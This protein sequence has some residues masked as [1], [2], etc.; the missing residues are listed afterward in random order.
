MKMYQVLADINFSDKM[1]EAKAQTA[2]GQELINKYRTY[3]VANPATC[4]TV[5]AFLSEAR[6]LS[7]DSGI[8]D[9]IESISNTVNANKFGWTLASICEN[10]ENGGNGNRNYLQMRAAEQVRPMLEM[11]EDEIVSYIKSGALK[12]VMYVEA[13]RNVAKAIYREQPVVEYSDT[14]TTVHPLSIYE[15]TDDCIYFHAAGHIYK[16]NNETITE[17][18]RN[19]VS[20]DFITVANMLESGL[21]KFV[22]NSLTMELNN[23][24]Y[25]ISEADEKVKCTITSEGKTTEYTLDQLRENNNYIIQA[26]PMNLKAQRSQILEGFAK[27][28]EN[29]KNIA[30]LNNVSIINNLNDRF[31]L[32][33]N[34]GSAY[35]KMLNTNHTQPWEVKGDIAQVCESIKKYTRLD[36]TKSYTK[37]IE[38]AIEEAKRQEGQQIKENLE[39][40]AIEKRKA[41]IAE[42]TERYKNDPV[43]LEMLS[44]VAAD[45]NKL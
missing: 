4:S 8:Q 10:I 27:V 22:D 30:I 31:I 42:L 26:T 21:V 16:T 6:K 20:S 39:K 1:F 13:F 2:L 17:A 32:I 29:Y 25:T 15:K 18:N 24:T 3:V 37:S 5:N 23:R 36:I 35:A 43:R 44:R 11:K 9:V 7:Y 40:E 28:F 34:N 12:N 45:L 19:D 33:E 38:N 14:Y 41:K